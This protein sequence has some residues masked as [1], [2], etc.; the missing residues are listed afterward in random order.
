MNELKDRNSGDTLRVLIVDDQ[1]GFR[2]QLRCLLVAAGLQVVGE[3][4]DIPE[5]LRQAET[6]QP[7]LA[8]VDIMLPGVSGIQG[9]HQIKAV[10]P[11]TRVILVSAYDFND[12][13]LSLAASAGAERFVCKDELDLQ[14]VSGWLQTGQTV[15]ARPDVA[16]NG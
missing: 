10:A 4:G 12:W 8:V 1:P 14:M 16:R 11:A 2:R 13:I 6:L 15:G 7:D 9:T 5:A 3:A